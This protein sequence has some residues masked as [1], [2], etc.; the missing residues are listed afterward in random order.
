MA[1]T[2]NEMFFSFPLKISVLFLQKNAH[3]IP[4]HLVYVALNRS[5]QEFSTFFYF[6]FFFLA[7]RIFF[8]VL[9][10]WGLTQVRKSYLA[11]QIPQLPAFSATARRVRIE[12][13]PE[14]A[15]EGVGTRFPHPWD[16]LMWSGWFAHRSM[17]SHYSTST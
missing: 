14:V 11:K 9:A 6:F 5:Y 15:G 13:S 7:Q 8:S 10:Y 16:V 4:V 12:V 2:L 17:A 3:F 1:N